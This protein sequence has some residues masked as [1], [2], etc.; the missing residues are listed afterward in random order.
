M[1]KDNRLV[2]SLGLHGIGKS[3]LVRNA[4][5]FI[6]ERK[7]F[8]GGVVLIQTKNVRDVFS[9]M[10]LIQRFII[11]ALDLSYKE[12]SEITQKHCTEEALLDF[13]IDYLND[14]KCNKPRCQKNFNNEHK[15][16]LICFDNAEE[17]IRRN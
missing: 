1:D 3:S 13:I 5:H 15:N 12:V 17:L 14:P 4:L 7:Y 11:Q 6:Y 10:K 16:F 9:L 8:T 2:A